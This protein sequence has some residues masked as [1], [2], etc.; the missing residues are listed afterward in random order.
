MAK[1]LPLQRISE[2]FRYDEETGNLYWKT[3]KGQRGKIDTIAGHLGPSGYVL[4]GFD[5]KVYRAHRI[6][7]A[8]AYSQSPLKDIDHID[9]DRSNN[10]LINLR[11]VSRSVNIQNNKVRGTWLV[12]SRWEAKIVTNQKQTYLGRFDTEAEAHQAYLAAK[13]IYHPEA[14]RN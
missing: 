9:G 13:K 12:G 6:I 10:R 14:K 1:E 7:Y 8:L 3:N 4:V 2:L 5:K 11:E